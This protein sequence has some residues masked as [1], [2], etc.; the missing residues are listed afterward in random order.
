MIKKYRQLRKITLE[1]LAEKCD[2]SWR[3]LIRIENGNYRNAKFSTIAKIIKVLNF[4]DK[5]IIKFIKSI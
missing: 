4:S 1:E 3:N 2:I 5:D